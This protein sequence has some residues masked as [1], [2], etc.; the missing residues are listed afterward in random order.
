MS[1]SRKSD[2]PCRSRGSHADRRHGT[3]RPEGS[4]EAGPP[5]LLPLLLRAALADWNELGAE[6]A[7]RGP[8][9]IVIALHAAR[10]AATGGAQLTTH[11][12]EQIAAWFAGVVDEAIRRGGGSGMTAMGQR[13]QSGRC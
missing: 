4:A 13:Q 9:R 11:E 7:A 8:H 12:E 6:L 1:S 10:A 2:K 3:T 5:L